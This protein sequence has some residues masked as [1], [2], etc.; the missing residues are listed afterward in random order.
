[1][2]AKVTEYGIISEGSI[3][4]LVKKAMQYIDKGWQPLGGAVSYGNGFFLQTF[5]R[6]AP[7]ESPRRR[8]K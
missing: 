5:V 8:I 2:A 1:M 7:K 4:R 3:E 6:Y